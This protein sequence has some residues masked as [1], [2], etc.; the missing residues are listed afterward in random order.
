MGKLWWLF[1]LFPFVFGI[2]NHSWFLILGQFKCSIFQYVVYLVVLKW[3]YQCLF[4]S[5]FIISIFSLFLSWT[6]Q[7]E[8]VIAWDNINIE[9][10]EF[11]MKKKKTVE[12]CCRENRMKTKKL[13]KKHY[14]IEFNVQCSRHIDTVKMSVHVTP[15]SYTKKLAKPNNCNSTRVIRQ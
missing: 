5:K 14:A 12:K 15:F 2:W 6:P 11:K 10:M 13:E 1:V 4:S 8:Y 3:L 7:I 9:V